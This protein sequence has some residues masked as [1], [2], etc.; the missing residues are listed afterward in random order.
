MNENTDWHTVI[1]VTD[2]G[3]I[4]YREYDDRY[5]AMDEISLR[6][7]LERFQR[8]VDWPGNFYASY[9]PHMRE[10]YFKAMSI[11]GDFIV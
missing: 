9:L 8:T 11:Y 2:S 1:T 10:L 6:E 7:F 4:F 5:Y 3:K